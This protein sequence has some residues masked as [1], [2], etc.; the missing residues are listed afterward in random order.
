MRDRRATR[1]GGD[2]VSDGVLNV[3]TVL[4]QVY[5]GTTRRTVLEVNG[6][7]CIFTTGSGIKRLLNSGDGP[8]PG[9]VGGTADSTRT[10]AQIAGALGNEKY[11]P[12]AF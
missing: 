6:G 11:G 5:P 9:D 8:I 2:K 1:R 12:A 4:L 7:L 3:T 10:A